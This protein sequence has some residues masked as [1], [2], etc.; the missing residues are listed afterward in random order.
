MPN[1]VHLPLLDSIQI[2]TPCSAR[3]EDMVGDDRVRHCAQC[4]LD[5][6]D[7]SAVGR[8]EA[9]RVLEGLA[10][11][12]VC[13]RFYRRAD[14]TI[15]TRDCPVGVARVRRAARRALVRV[16]AMIG[17]VG[18]T[19]VAAATMSGDSWG[20]RMRLRALRPFSTVCEWIAPTPPPPPIRGMQLM[21]DVGPTP[22]APVPSPTPTKG[23]GA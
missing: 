11:G 3:W 9:E 12:R 15:L 5:V 6:H 16:A 22:M 7:L 13:A 19:G 18:A 8:E 1:V 23:G 21:G 20:G 17:L 2:A 10:R 14:G 4:D